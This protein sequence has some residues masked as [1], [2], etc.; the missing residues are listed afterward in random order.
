MQWKGKFEEGI[1]V[2]MAD[3]IM[4]AAGAL[5]RGSITD[6]YNAIKNKFIY[7]DN[8]DPELTKAYRSNLK[9]LLSDM[10]IMVI[11]GTFIAGSLG[12]WADEEEKKAKKSGH[13]SDAFRATF[14]NLVHRTVKNS[15]LDANW[16]SAIFDVSMDWNPF[17]TTYLANEAATLW[18]FATGDESAAD[19]LVKSFS[20]AR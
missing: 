6:A 10:F 11:I 12:D 5:G 8:V 14:A 2:T 15:S 16:V 13:L 4:Q 17:A 3:A 9:M 1:A 18:N 19:T 20:A 7:N